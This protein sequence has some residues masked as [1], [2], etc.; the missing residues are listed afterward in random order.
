VTQRF[1]VTRLNVLTQE[2]LRLEGLGVLH[3][4]ADLE[5][6]PGVYLDPGQ[7]PGH[8]S[9]KVPRNTMEIPLVASLVA[10]APQRI[11]ATELV[12]WPLPRVEPVLLEQPLFPHQRIAVDRATRRGCL[13]LADQ[14]GLGKTR[15][16]G[17]AAASA[18][19]AQPDRAVLILGPSYLA[20][21]WRGEL[22]ALGLLRGA[23]FWQARGA[24]PAQHIASIQGAKW[25]FCHYDILRH[26][27]SQLS[28]G[29]YAAVIFDEAHLLSNPKS[30]RSQAAALVTP[31]TALRMVLTG[32]PV[33]NSIR[34]AHSLLTLTTGPGAWGS[35]LTFRQRYASAMHNG[36][37]WQDGAP[38]HVEEL[39]QRLD[40]VYLRRDVSVLEQPLP[41][42]TR[43][44][45][46]V[47]LDESAAATV[48]DLLQGYSP[49]QVLD[50]IRKN[51]A[52]K[53]TI[54]WLGQLRKATS[55]AK[56]PTT[57]AHVRSLLEQGDSVLV[58]AWTRAMAQSLGKALSPSYIVTGEDS[59]ATRDQIVA[60]W[61]ADTKPVPLIATFGTLST[62]VT[63]TKANHVVFH[64]LD[65]VP[66]TML[67]AE[68]R[69]YRIGQKRP[70]QS[71]WCVAEGTL[72][73][74]IYK[75]VQRKA[76]ATAVFG[77]LGT[78]DLADFFGDSLAD[79][80]VEDLMA[81]S[82]RHSE[83]A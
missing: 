72:D 45:L 37:G 7:T 6:I 64:D 25:I 38:S 83:D 9:V 52:G 8:W 18:L 36:Y 56:A 11:G 32:T 68:G 44:K 28:L 63:L 43:Q 13:L 51:Q 54:A 79:Q 77:E 62:G 34:E 71:W 60:G 35:G 67:Q 42:R 20:S 73:P 49:K 22:D 19:A 41:E 3:Q 61:K 48:A 78:Q 80:D 66:A 74:F 57:I 70:V 39:Q 27:W 21:T 2:T 29:R 69:V 23:P 30:A 59:T 81:W 17:A 14:L 47:E 15:S 40:G 58:F 50:A 33:Q 26:W 46:S 65:F 53:A 1:T 16:A 55:R 82:L 76:P 10:R 4:A 75:L 31:G 5:R 12:P 24:D